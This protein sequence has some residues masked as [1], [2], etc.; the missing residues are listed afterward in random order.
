MVPGAKEVIALA[1]TPVPV[2]FVVLSFAM[3]GFWVVLQQ[4]PRA[5][6]VAP[7]SYVT[8]PPLDAED[9]VI[10]EAS[11]VVTVGRTASVTIVIWFPYMVPALFVA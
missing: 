3:V 10:D 1:K 7:P 6:T 5:L 9:D 2:P 8:L 11:V 4:T